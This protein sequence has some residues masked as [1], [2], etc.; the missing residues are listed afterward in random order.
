MYIYV[1]IMYLYDMVQV[2]HKNELI[3]ICTRHAPPDRRSQT[4]G[5][6]RLWAAWYGGTGVKTSAK[7]VDM[8]DRG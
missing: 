5:N 3:Q 1:I 7:I 2:L 8:P 6:L 4:F